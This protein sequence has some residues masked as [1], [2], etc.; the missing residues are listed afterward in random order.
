MNRNTVSKHLKDHLLFF[1]IAFLPYYSGVAILNAQT[2]PEGA[3]FF[4]ESLTVSRGKI[5]PSSPNAE[6]WQKSL[7]CDLVQKEWGWATCEG[8]DAF[9]VGYDQLVNNVVFETPNSDGLVTFDD[10]KAESLGDA[11]AQIESSLKDSLKEQSKRVGANI[12]FKGWRVYPTLNEEKKI[13]YYATD[14]DWGGSISTNI[15][16]SI[17][18]RRGY[19]TMF[20][21]PESSNLDGAAIERIVLDA[22]SHYSP[23]LSESYTE[24]VTGDRVAVAGAVGVLATLIGVKYSKGAFAGI[25]LVLAMIL[26]K[27]WVLL[28]LPFYWLK[29]AFK[30]KRDP[31]T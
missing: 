28:I 18:D 17:F 4:T 2:L 31:N 1:I 25:M 24:F 21:V 27:V 30:R 5:N 29:N 19:V 6:V 9:I 7:W 23:S 20:L 14:I 3:S 8:V 13:L 11:I 10:W 12:T 15:K 22:A 16:A 26:K